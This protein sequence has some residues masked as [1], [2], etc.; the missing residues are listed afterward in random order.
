MKVDS[1]AA[2][3]ALLTWVDL[4]VLKEEDVNHYKLLEVAEEAP[5]GTKT[6]PRPGT[7]AFS[8][9]Q[10]GSPHDVYH[11]H[12]GRA[13]R[14]DSPAAASGADEGILEGAW[15]RSVSEHNG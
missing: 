15:I 8:C 7:R 14:I 6:V 12:R 4:G 3:K 10:G 5:A 1:T 2:I 13:G 9:F 11:S